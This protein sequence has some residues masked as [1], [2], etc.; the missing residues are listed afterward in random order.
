MTYCLSKNYITRM[1]GKVG[2]GKEIDWRRSMGKRSD[3]LE[4]GGVEPMG[5]VVDQC[6]GVRVKGL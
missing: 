4:A 1:M 5:E 2:R 6:T 3:V